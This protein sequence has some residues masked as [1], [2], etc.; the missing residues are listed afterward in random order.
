MRRDI[1][2]ATGGGTHEMLRHRVVRLSP[3]IVLRAQD[4]ESDPAPSTSQ[5]VNYTE[6]A[7]A[8][9]NWID[10]NQTTDWVIGYSLRSA[11]GKV[12]GE[13]H[14]GNNVRIASVYKAFLLAAALK[15]NSG[16]GGIKNDLEEMIYRSDD[17]AAVRVMSNVTRNYF[18]TFVKNE[19]GLSGFSLAS[20]PGNSLIDANQMSSAFAALPDS[21][22][23]SH[24]EKIFDMLASI[25]PAQRWGL[26]RAAIKDD[27]TWHAKSGWL[28]DSSSGPA[29]TSQVGLFYYP[30]NEKA[31]YITLA[32][33]QEFPNVTNVDDSGDHL[34]GAIGTK[35]LNAFRTIGH[36]I[37][38][39][40]E[41]NE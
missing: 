27:W 9:K 14:Q 12:L 18:E 32:V 20:S 7:A 3:S 38:I 33:T 30:E 25:I 31:N 11:D 4:T 1:P 5:K 39:G 34:Q 41:S 21:A 37:F 2:N 29:T 24:R 13:Y 8:V 16:Y 22:G 26:I 15:K 19:L 40:T 17:A 28:K 10:S 23:S 36:L 35:A 6:R